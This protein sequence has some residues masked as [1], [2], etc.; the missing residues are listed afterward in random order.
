ME[1]F[2][3]ASANNW[4]T[5]PMLKTQIT[6]PSKDGLQLSGTLFEPDETKGA[7]MIAPATGIKQQ[8]YTSFASYLCENGYA[9]VTFDNRGIGQSIRGGINDG[10]P[11]LTNWGSLDMT[12]VLE[13]LKSNFPDQDYHLIGHSAGGQLVGLMENAR[14][15][16]SM[17][18]FGCS[19]GSI[20]NAKYPFKFL[21]FFYL[22]IFIPVSNLIFGQ[23]NSQWVGM[24][25]P[26]PKEVSREWSRWCSG[27]G[28]VNVD[29]NSRI[30]DHLYDDLTFNTLV[31]ACC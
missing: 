17:F 29:L 24:G 22:R 20:K 23:T 30:K 25:E 28:Y 18:N 15:L 10:N 9:V 8:F 3:N 4:S 13:Y 31:A 1:E 6:I 26:L 5:I 19:S 12:A 2:K 21:S 11:S 14:D 27:T 16:K 7:M